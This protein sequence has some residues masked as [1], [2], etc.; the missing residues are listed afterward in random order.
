MAQLRI[1]KGKFSL[2]NTTISVDD[3]AE[4]IFN[5]TAGVPRLVDFALKLL[6]DN[7][8][9]KKQ[10]TKEFLEMRTFL[11]AVHDYT[12][13]NGGETELTNWQRLDPKRHELYHQFVYDAILS[14][15][16]AT[17]HIL[18]DKELL[19]K[20]VTLLHALWAIGLYTAKTPQYE[21]FK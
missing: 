19:G 18:S 3:L 16:Y 21:V 6:E 11:G 13:N 20:E 9:K 15:P 14:I 4:A 2:Q 17:N 7:Y 5:V 8:I 1:A 12:N 10:I